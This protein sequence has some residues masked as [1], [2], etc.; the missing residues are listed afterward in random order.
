MAEDNFNMSEQN[1][2][3][4]LVAIFEKLENLK[5]NQ[6]ISKRTD[7]K[8]PIR[9]EIRALEFYRSVISECLASFVYVFI[10]CG[11]VAGAGVG[12][13]ISSMLLAT[14]L[15]SGFA[16]TSLTQCFGHI[17]GAHV[18]PAVTIAMGV[19]KRI[20]LLRT[21]SFVI[22]QCGGAIAGTA[23]LYSV[24]VPGYQANL[25]TTLNH[26]SSVAPWER[27][28]VE[29]IL[30]FIIVFSYFVSMESH[31]KWMTSSALT[32]GATYSAC[33]FVSMPYLNPARSL[34]PS[35]VLNRWDSHW[36]YWLGPVIGGIAA[37][38]TYEYIF[39]ST[40]QRKTSKDSQDEESSSIRSDEDTYDDLD[41]PNQ[42]KFHGS[43]YNNYRGIGSGPGYCASLASVGLYSGPTK[44]LER[45]ESLYGGTKSLFCKSPPLTRANLNRSQSVYAKSNTGINREVIPNPGPLVPAQ[46]LYPMRLNQ[47]SHIHNQ[48]AQ[49]QM[50][51]S[52]G[53]YGVRGPPSGTSRTDNY[54]TTERIHYRNNQ[55]EGSSK[56]EPNSKYEDNSKSCRT[57]R[58]ES[59][60]GIVPS[61]QRR[62]QSANQ[63]EE[64]CYAWNYGT[65]GRNQHGGNYNSGA[66]AVFPGKAQ[67]VNNIPN[68]M[69]RNV[70]GSE[71]RQPSP[72]Q[73]GSTQGPQHSPNSQY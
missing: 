24:T 5:N 20:T 33:S 41:K 55:A 58:P 10:V 34:G 73:A 23:F 60:Y 14:A 32:I 19:T 56:Y 49:N 47:T 9:I 12:A 48:N 59:M 71:V 29:L 7:S 8:T 43:T 45:V 42:P 2:E 35:F 54:S 40:R 62:G 21:I 50:Q 11:A 51:H 46:S 53:L 64:N 57:T 3:Y 65:A 69:T 26:S 28:G 16:M 52:E 68:Y 25:S 22:A 1:V 18:N 67:P 70:I 17:S 27:F 36:V 4:H 39:N 66:S 37:G 13:S 38:V 63:N 6:I 30:T 15:A 31:R 72:N 44:Q 61:Q